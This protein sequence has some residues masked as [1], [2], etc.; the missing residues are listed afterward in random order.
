MASLTGRQLGTSNKQTCQFL[1]IVGLKPKP[2]LAQCSLTAISTVFPYLDI[3]ED[4]RPAAMRQGFINV[5]GKH[6]DLLGH[7][8]LR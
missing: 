4:F 7:L 5:I 2:R 3:A 8:F 6:L 1:P